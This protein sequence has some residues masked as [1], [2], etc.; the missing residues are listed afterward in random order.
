MALFESAHVV[1]TPRGTRPVAILGYPHWVEAELVE[2]L[3]QAAVDKVFDLRQ[4]LKDPLEAYKVEWHEDATHD[5][6]ILA[7]YGQEPF[8][9]TCIEIMNYVHACGQETDDPIM[10]LIKCRS[11]YHRSDT[12]GRTTEDCFNRFVIDGDR[13]YNAQFFNLNK[14]QGRKHKDARYQQVEEAVHWSI[15]PCGLHPTP[16]GRYAETVV[17]ER[18]KAMLNF[19]SITSYLEGFNEVNSLPRRYVPLTPKNPDAVGHGRHQ[20]L[21]TAS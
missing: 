8:S 14:L 16:H 20:H 18:A 1:D 11:S 12:V 5:A 17:L 15:N 19:R 6:T 3:G 9:D 13:A 2:I 10:I 21:I 4:H 7:V